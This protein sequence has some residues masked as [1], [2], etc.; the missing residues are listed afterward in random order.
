MTIWIPDLSRRRGPRYLAIADALADDIATGQLKEGEQLPTH[1]ELAYQ[2]G[3][4]VGTVS[5]AYAEAESRGLTAGEVGRGTFV[6]KSSSAPSGVPLLVP[7]HHHPGIVDFGLNLPVQGDGPMRLAESVDRLSKAP[8]VLCKL[9][10]YQP[11]LGL[12]RHR[13]AGAAWLR[14][15]KVQVDAERVAVTS[16]AQHGLAATL[17]AITRPGALV[18]TEQLSW[19]GIKDLADQLHLRLHG[20]A[21]DDDGL[22]PDA[23]EAACRSMQPVVLY[24]MP[25]LQNPTA[26]IMPEERRRE[27][28][29]VARHYGVTIIEDDVYGFL[30]GDAVPTP[31][32][33]L[34]P[35]QV[36]YITSMAK[37]LMPGLR[38]GFVAAPPGKIDR[39]GAAVRA[40]IR[41]TPPLMAEIVSD[42]IETGSAAAMAAAQLDHVRQRQAIAREILGRVDL[43]GHG[44]TSDRRAF[45]IWLPLP[46]SWNGD[47]FI[48]EARRQEVIL[49][50]AQPF[51]IGRGQAPRYVRVCLGGPP[52]LADVERGL[53]VLAGI[54]ERRMAPI[55]AVV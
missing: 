48:A 16:G 30:L 44:P 47:D 5:R 20:V 51:Q 17:M 34:A 10:D 8:G 21:M 9:L 23:F 29:N 33:S 43:G 32:A 26:V 46:D 24:T 31:L 35:E 13:A 27:I 11:E 12:A 28:V 7:D 55:R 36:Y 53:T 49:M 6:R 54:L 38:V 4:T 42:W 3:I 18:L 2:L 37:C 45:H 52:T 1:R 40:T 41:M 39:I 50:S 19:P 15:T 14:G 25:T 22:R